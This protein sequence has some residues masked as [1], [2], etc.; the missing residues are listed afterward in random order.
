VLIIV[1]IRLNSFCTYRVYLLPE[2]M[3]ITG[4]KASARTLITSTHFSSFIS[5]TLDTYILLL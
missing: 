2:V 5:D 4:M 1:N 3:P